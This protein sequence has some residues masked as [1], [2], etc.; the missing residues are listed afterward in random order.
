MN[1]AGCKKLIVYPE[2]PA[3]LRSADFDIAVREKSNSIEW[4]ANGERTKPS[5]YSLRTEEESFHKITT[6]TSEFG[7]T[8]SIFV[9]VTNLKA[10][11]VCLEKSHCSNFD[12]FSLL[13]AGWRIG[14]LEGA[15]PSK[16]CMSIGP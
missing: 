15:M 9:E 5:K 12:T 16:S 7:E 11:Q 4:F 8:V 13:S 10:S 3:W 2:D 14:I 6:N 1:Q